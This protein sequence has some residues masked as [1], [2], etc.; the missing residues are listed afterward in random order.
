M[1]KK[2]KRK[3]WGLS[4]MDATSQAEVKGECP[5]IVGRV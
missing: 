4:K 5:E 2:K 1:C 3:M